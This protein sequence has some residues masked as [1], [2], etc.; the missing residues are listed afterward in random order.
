[1]ELGCSTDNTHAPEIKRSR[2]VSRKETQE[3]L[4]FLASK[5]SDHRKE[6]A[7]FLKSQDLA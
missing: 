4:S 3:G 2:Y 6:P 5:L 1:M 7:S